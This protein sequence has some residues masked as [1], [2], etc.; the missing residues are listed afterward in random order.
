MAVKVATGELLLD[1]L[2]E[3]PNV[4][5]AVLVDTRGYIIEKRGSALSLKG[6]G[7]EEAGAPIADGAKKGPSENLY[8]VEA[9]QD[10]L[11]VV[12]DD[13]LNFERLKSAVDETLAEFGMAP[14]V[15]DE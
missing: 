2:L 13:R 1:S 6:L 5:A 10:F 14:A 15:D 9:G 12:F 11:I 4:K 7:A 3:N 8:L